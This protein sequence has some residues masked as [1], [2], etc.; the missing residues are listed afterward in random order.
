MEPQ[1]ADKA[2][3]FAAAKK[4]L[5]AGKGKDA[6]NMMTAAAYQYPNDPFVLSYYGCLVSVVGRRHPEGVKICRDAVALL[7]KTMPVGG[8]FFL[9]QLFLNLGRAYLAG[10]NKTNAVKV[11]S[12]G[13]KVDPDNKELKAE[14][15]GLGVRHKPPIGFLKRDNP[16]NKYIG[17]LLYSMKKEK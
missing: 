9:P 6:L 1:K 8:E 10:G 17:M 16:I 13:L 4:L 7:K 11:F 5:K 14:M 3:Y 12:S 15:K 2:N